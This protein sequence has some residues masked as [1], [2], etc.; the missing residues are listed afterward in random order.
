LD[1]KELSDIIGTNF[2]KDIVPNLNKNFMVMKVSPEK[3]NSKN[4]FYES[5]LLFIL[6]K[7]STST[8][9][10]ISQIEI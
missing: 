10:I 9:K 3:L 8:Q 7:K 6:P 1:T 5:V 4:V 2:I